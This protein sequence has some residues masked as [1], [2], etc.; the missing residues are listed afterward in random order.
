MLPRMSLRLAWHQQF[1][2]HVDSRRT[3]ASDSGS[4]SCASPDRG[5][6]VHLAARS[7][8]DLICRQGK[9]WTMTRQGSIHMPILN[10]GWT[11][12]DREVGSTTRLAF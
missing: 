3:W 10:A 9:P 7:L 2:I 12:E 4:E 11:T 8:H 1:G 5:R 6:H